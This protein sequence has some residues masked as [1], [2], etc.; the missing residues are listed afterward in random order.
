MGKDKTMFKTKNKKT[1]YKK[2][3]KK[4]NDIERMLTSNEAVLEGIAIIGDMIASM[5]E[6]QEDLIR[7]QNIS[8][9]LPEDDGLVPQKVDEKTSKRPPGIME[10]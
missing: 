6:L 10:Q 3:E 4:D 9:N 2:K 8:I 5:V 1:K 7:K